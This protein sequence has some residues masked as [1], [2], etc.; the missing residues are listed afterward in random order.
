MGPFIVS[1]ALGISS[2]ALYTA[3]V[4]YVFRNIDMH[5]VYTTVLLLLFVFVH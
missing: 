2:W 3:L 1:L 4:R 5:T